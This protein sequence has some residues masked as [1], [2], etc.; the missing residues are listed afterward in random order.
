[1][2]KKLHVTLE[3]PITT[4]DIRYAQFCAQ[5]LHDMDDSVM[6]INPDIPGLDG[7]TVRD[8]NI[9]AVGIEKLDEYDDIPGEDDD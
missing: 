6:F 3:R 5:E 8:E 2:S 4:P 9:R 7:V 1:M